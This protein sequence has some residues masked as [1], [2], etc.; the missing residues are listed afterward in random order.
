MRVLLVCLSVCLC[1]L[2]DSGVAS[3]CALC[4]RTIATVCSM[5][6]A[7]RLRS[8]QKM[9]RNKRLPDLLPACHTAAACH[10]CCCLFV[11]ATS[12]RNEFYVGRGMSAEKKSCLQCVCLTFQLWF[13]FRFDSDDT[14]KTSLASASHSNNNDNNSNNNN[15]LVS[16][17]IC[18]QFRYAA[19]TSGNIKSDGFI[20]N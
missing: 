14:V 9:A 3:C 16:F 8:A 6:Q 11:V 10:G 5:I 12:V 18:Q 4:S 20:A 15:T 13:S 7:K 1:V 2:S 19:P 17:V